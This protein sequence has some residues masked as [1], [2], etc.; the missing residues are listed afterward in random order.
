MK[1]S[2]L[3]QFILDTRDPRSLNTL[4]RLNYIASRSGAKTYL[5]IGVKEGETFLNLD[6]P[7]KVGVDP[8]FKFDWQK[9]KN[10]NTHLVPKI[11][12]E[13]FADL[14]NNGPIAQ[15]LAQ[16]WPNE[17]KLAFDIIFIDGLHTFAQSFRDFENSLQFSHEQTVWVMD[18]TVPSNPYSAV[19]N[20]EFCTA[21]CTLAGFV[22][23]HWHGD[24]YKSVMA[25]H[26]KYSDISYC[27][28]MGFNPQTVFWKAAP[29][30]RNA[31]FSSLEEINRLNYFDIFAYAHLFIPVPDE[32]FP[33]LLGK[34]TDPQDYK[35]PD[36]WQRLVYF[37]VGKGVSKEYL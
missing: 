23:P 30:Q 31:E 37:N 16:H 18:D 12:D 5:E 14:K 4:P 13:F 22:T 29:N 34:T 35:E 19:P 36:I 25:I 7:F 27:T 28:L 24:V 10:N 33:L 32:E 2:P 21:L 8:D 6:L 15:Q 20:L 11:S 26:N 1:T 17:N 3:K 9:R